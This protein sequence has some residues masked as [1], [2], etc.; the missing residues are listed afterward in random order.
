M[1]TIVSPYIC[2]V[3]YYIL[4][5]N[6]CYGRDQWIVL[7]LTNSAAMFPQAEKHTSI[8]IVPD[9]HLHSYRSFAVEEF[10]LLT[11]AQPDVRLPCAER[12]PQSTN[13]SCRK[14]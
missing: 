8:T 4:A 6:D 3:I 5:G 9:F 13:T 10:Y 14:L 7:P 11:S 12:I 2:G 1:M